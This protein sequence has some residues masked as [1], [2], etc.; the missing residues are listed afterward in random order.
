MTDT[1]ATATGDDAA[2]VLLFDGECGLCSR[3]VQTILNNERERHT[4]RF[5]P[6]NGEYGRALRA[7]HPELDSIDSMIWYDPPAGTIRARS[8]A[9]LCVC[10]YLGGRFRL[11]AGIGRLMPRRIRDWLYGVL[12][13]HRH[14][15]P[16]GRSRTCTLSGADGQ[17][18]RFLL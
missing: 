2:P 11:Y 17:S 7:R 3:A 14:R 13:R 8:D 9:A 1:R 12:A 18:E 16:V 10:R 15:I 5:A 4:L 6:L